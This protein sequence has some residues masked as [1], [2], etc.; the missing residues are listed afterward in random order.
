[1]PLWIKQWKSKWEYNFTLQQVGL[2]W[3]YFMLQTLVATVKQ[4]WKKKYSIRPEFLNVIYYVS[5]ALKEIQ[6]K[7][8]ME[9]SFLY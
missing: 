7:T 9:K 4:T 1:M 3:S 2:R 5:A 8:T 6:S